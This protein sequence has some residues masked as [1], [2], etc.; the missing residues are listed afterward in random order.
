M[1]EA[2][3]RRFC[4]C[5]EPLLSSASLS[6]LPPLWVKRTTLSFAKHSPLF[7]DYTTLSKRRVRY[8]FFQ[9]RGGS[10]GFEVEGVVFLFWDEKEEVIY[11]E[12]KE[13]FSPFLL[14]FWVLHTFFP[15]VLRFANKA[16]FLHAG[17]VVFEREPLLF[18]A[19]SGGGKSTLT[20]QLLLRGAS[21]LGDDALPL[22]SKEGEIG[23][24]GAYPFY[25]PY[26]ASESLGYREK[27]FTPSFYRL[28]KVFLLK[29]VSQQAPL[30]LRP[31][32][33]R[34]K[35]EALYLHRYIPFEQ[36]KKEDFKQTSFLARHLLVWELTLPWS[37][38]RFDEVVVLLKR[39]LE[40]DASNEK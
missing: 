36:L 40:E 15:L 34:E 26:R 10:W 24:I 39:L 29:R 33:G 9:K 4:F 8:V 28:R 23:V 12:P 6:L 16:Y 5:D 32:Q 7:S 25:R 30:S 13:A 18:L 1:I 31:L 11:Y 3:G 22:L 14:R 27:S 19:P 17:G 2:F 38:E 21:L 35:F 20:H 37:L